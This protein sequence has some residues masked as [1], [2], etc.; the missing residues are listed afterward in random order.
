M[1]QSC[2]VKN[3]RLEGGNR[4]KAVLTSSRLGSSSTCVNDKI[5]GQGSVRASRSIRFILSRQSQRNSEGLDGRSDEERYKIQTLKIPKTSCRREIKGS[6]NRRDIPF[7]LDGQLINWKNNETG[8]RKKKRGTDRSR[9][10]LT[11]EAALLKN[12]ISPISIATQN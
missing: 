2:G 5:R 9:A 1:Y 4:A 7:K 12:A 3:S 8:R 11:S 6:A 10:L